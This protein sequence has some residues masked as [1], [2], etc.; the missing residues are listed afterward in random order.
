MSLAKETEPQE[1]PLNI[2]SLQVVTEQKEIS[3]CLFLS[4]EE[5]LHEAQSSFH[6]KTRPPYLSPVK[7][8]CRTKSNS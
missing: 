2:P 7:P 5:K 3:V 8:V 1:H 6:S 4:K